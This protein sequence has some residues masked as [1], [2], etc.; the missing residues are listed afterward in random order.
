MSYRQS[1]SEHLIGRV[2]DALK[3][4]FGEQ[5]IFQDKSSIPIGYD[6]TEYLNQ[7]IG[8][9]RVL[10]VV[11]GPDWLKELEKRQSKTGKDWV[12]TEIKTALERR[13]QIIPLLVGG[14]EL[15]NFED[16]PED[17]Q[18]LTLYTGTAART[19]P[20]FTQDMIRL[21]KAIE[22]HLTKEE[23]LRTQKHSSEDKLHTEFRRKLDRVSELIEELKHQIDC[24]KKFLPAENSKKLIEIVE[25]I[26]KVT[27]Y[28]TELKSILEDIESCIEAGIWLLHSTD[29]IANGIS[30]AILEQAKTTNLIDN[31]YKGDLSRK[32][33]Q[34]RLFHDVKEYLIWI[35][36]YIRDGTTPR[37]DF[38]RELVNLDFAEDVYKQ[39]FELIIDEFVNPASSQLSTNAADMLASYINIYLIDDDENWKLLSR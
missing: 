37:N 36:K 24:Q 19:D 8:S 34:R 11:I 16:L 20:D 2:Y 4:H 14:A 39:G 22:N 30:S 3:N 15:P 9:C 32:E 28:E 17:I 21:I 1:D 7:M 18:R 10:I 25:R 27:T 38:A 33:L 5:A 35:Q 29:Y 23:E 12:H 26:Q 31:S 13:I 6:Y